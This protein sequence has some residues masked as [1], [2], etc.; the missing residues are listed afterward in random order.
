MTKVGDVDRVAFDAAGSLLAQDTVAWAVGRVRAAARTADRSSRRLVIGLHTAAEPHPRRD[1]FPEPPDTPESFRMRVADDGREVRVLVS[2]SDHCGLGYAL[3]ELAERMEAGRAVEAVGAEPEEEQRPAVPVRSIQRAFSSVHEDSP[4]FHDRSFWDEYLDFLAA[5]R[6]NRFH[7]A[8]GLQYNYGAEMTNAG[9]SDNYLCFPYPF[10]FDVP[11]FPVRAQGVGKAEQARN[12]DSLTYVARETRR[13]GMGFQLGLWNHSYDYGL[14]A[15]HNHP[16]LGIGPESHADY[17]ASALTQLLATIPEIDGLTFR[18]H[19]E[20]GIR[21]DNRHAFWERM[22]QAVSDTGRPMR[23]DLHAKGLDAALIAALNKPNIRPAAS[24]KY[25]AEHLGLPYH[26]ASIREMEMTPLSRKQ[27]GEERVHLMGVAE[28]ARRFTRYGYA[29]FLDEDRDIDVMFRMWA[30]AKLL[31]WGDPALARG[32][33]RLATLGG[34]L[35]TE[36]AEPLFFKG[37]KGSGKPGERDPYIRDDLRL[38]TGDWRKYQYG[39]LL[40]GRLLYDPDCPPETWRRFLRKEYGDSAAE[41]EALLAPLSRII[42]LV[43]VTHAPSAS[44]NAYWPEVYADL[45]VSPWVRSRHYGWDTKSADWTG[46]SSFDPTLFYSVGE[47]ADDA[48]A[49]NVRGKYTPLEVA[50]WIER[51]VGEG[52]AVAERVRERL[53]TGG[54]QARRLLV[55]TEILIRLGRFFAGKFRAAVEYALFQRTGEHRHIR[56]A[57][58]ILAEAHAAY[59]SITDVADGVYRDELTFGQVLSERGHWSKN[60]SAMADDLHA[61]RVERDRAAGQA[62]TGTGNGRPVLR[63]SRPRPDGIRLDAPERFERGAPLDVS[64]V[65]DPDV[66]SGVTRATLHFRHLDQ[67]KTWNETE[68][69][70]DGREFTASLPAEFTASS[71]PVM[72]F[73]EVGFGNEAPVLLPGFESDL[74]NQPYLVIH[75]SVWKGGAQQE[76]V[77]GET[78]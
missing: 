18:V 76:A 34:S 47:Y 56:D 7:L 67:S 21:D 48:L 16:I 42:P 31:L 51:F 12:L 1:G 57:V 38:G 44:N 69:S 74:A 23:V 40:W 58:D 5:Q 66:L 50:A 39:Y 54:P 15:Q 78:G 43:T 53:A 68:M 65:G 8:L 24:L 33:G 61:L 46:V 60:V 63:E 20:G 28:M 41:V 59:A 11:G 26:Q 64:L 49:G 2:A 71:F 9:A 3:T 45:P 17:C 13:R 52:E 4:W 10:L 27:L 75:S 22:F 14:G 36:F 25:W 35:G 55:D 62:D 37:R 29:D 6:F 70:L 32:Y 30:G 72:C 19:Y 77:P 73:A